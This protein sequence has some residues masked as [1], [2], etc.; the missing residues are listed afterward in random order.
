[1]KKIQHDQM[2][3]KKRTAPFERFKDKP[4]DVD[5]KVMD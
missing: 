1:M 3:E 4:I 5:F 2:I